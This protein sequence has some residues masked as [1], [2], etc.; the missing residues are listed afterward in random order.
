[1]KGKR[2]VQGRYKSK[3]K[4]KPPFTNCIEIRS[5]YTCN[6]R[7]M[8]CSVVSGAYIEILRLTA[9]YSIIKHVANYGDMTKMHVQ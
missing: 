7:S 6:L 4:R 9:I 3:D 8:Y 1:M 5:I 2:L